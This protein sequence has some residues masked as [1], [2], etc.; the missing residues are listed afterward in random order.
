MKPPIPP[1]CAYLML[2]ALLFVVLASAGFLAVNLAVN[3]A[4]QPRLPC[5]HVASGWISGGYSDAQWCMYGHRFR[6]YGSYYI[7]TR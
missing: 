1:G 3:Y 6:P 2:G 5:G 4:S 7:P